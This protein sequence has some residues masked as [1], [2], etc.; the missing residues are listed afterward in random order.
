MDDR[1][2]L[3]SYRAKRDFS[4]TPE[5][6]QGGT[7]SDKALSFVIQKHDA[8][9]LHYDFRLELQGAL[10]SWAVPKGPSLDPAVKR[11]G[12]RVEDHPISYAGFEGSIPARQYGAGDVIV[13]D[14]GLWTPHGD[15]A[16]SLKAGKLK[17]ELHGEKL[18]GGWTLVR[19][20][21]RGDESHE[22]WLL[23]K[24][25]DEHA[26]PEKDYDVL[27]AQ[28]N[29][30]LSG[31]PLPRDAAEKPAKAPRKA[32]AKKA[33]VQTAGDIPEGAVKAKLPELLAPQLATLVA[34][35]PAD[36]QGWA[37]EIKYDG[38][39]LLARIDGDSVRLMTRNGN[40]WTRKLPRLAEAV[41][42][43]E[44]PSGWMDGEIVVM[45]E[46]GLPDFGALQNAFDHASTARI[47]YYVFDLPYFD[48][49]DL[50]RLPL[51]RRRELL[52]ALVTRHPQETI[53]F[54]D[55]FEETPQDLLESAR[56]V[57]LEGVIG[58]RMDSAYVSR[59]S[60]DWI[61]LKTQL[62]QEFV[63]GGYTEPKGSRTGLGALM[64]G[65]HD[66]KGALRYAGNVGTGFNDKV[67]KDL[68]ARLEKIHTERSPFAAKL[69]AGVKG[70]F[71]KPRLLAEVAFGEWTHSGHIRHS[72]FQGLRS[73]KPATRI[74]REKPAALKS[75]KKGAAVIPSKQSAAKPSAAEKPSAKG[76]AQGSLKAA[77]KAPG[78]P[79]SAALKSLRITHADRVI[80][81]STGFT[82]QNVV[83]HYAQVAAL[84]L[85]HLKARP[86]A[87]VRAPSGIGG[88]LFFQKHAEATSIPGIKLLDTA[89]DPGHGPLLEVP[90]A[91]ALL[92]AA[93]LNVI[94]FHTWNATTRAIH[95]P[96][97]MT[98]DLDPGEGVAWPQVQEAAQLVRAFLD[99]L[100]LSSFL[101]TSGG[102]GL[103]VVVPLKRQYDFDTVKDF[104]HALVLHLAA[105]IP[106]R[107]AAKSGPKNRLGKIFPD[108]LRNGFGATTVCAW[109]LR[110]RPGMGVSVPVAWDELD[111]LT[112]GAHWTALTLGARL[113]V[114]N[115]PW[116]AYE[117]SRMGLSA[118]MKQLGFKPAAQAK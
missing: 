25:H 40:D 107:F 97:R 6:A 46:H 84:M 21:G 69:P 113:A 56:R 37:Y 94:E 2:S 78:K 87:L 15:P 59:R 47:V 88:E 36:P 61:K 89:L 118:A 112:G 26:R 93:Q 75:G 48:G 22:P 17:F 12:V 96:D 7:R 98:L 72:V 82:K 27:Q 74:V 11:M 102:K 19:M 8:R 68:K 117:A 43:L 109:S 64:L 73:D 23:I 1:D 10:K 108:Y 33:A 24:E 9:N 99:E 30:V 53:R 76:N 115:Q 13:W 28:P 62:R 20:R 54:S 57:G 79:A 63:I 111:S 18:K 34:A 55:T 116:D 4:R 52:C 114:G 51:S 90:S 81:S 92:A 42:A 35:P 44:I 67:L 101:K 66:D 16:R 77:A 100:K 58:K 14:R 39:R 103:H 105:V 110:A 71:V 65:V 95:K 91:A 49:L 32:A 38:Y 50:R 80:D 106:Q 31:R 45:N 3:K 41:A 83:E 60:P 104:S 85:P 70:Q 29:S 86:T 5:P